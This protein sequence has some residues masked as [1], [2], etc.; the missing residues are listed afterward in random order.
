MTIP[1][2]LKL[3]LRRTKSSAIFHTVLGPAS[4]QETID[5]FQNKIFYSVSMDPSNHGAIKMFPLIVRFYTPETNLKTCV[6][7]FYED[8]D[9]TAST[10]YNNIITT[11]DTKY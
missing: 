4:I 2:L 10:I 7:D 6:L 9:E 11:S 5:S 3:T 8:S 1:K